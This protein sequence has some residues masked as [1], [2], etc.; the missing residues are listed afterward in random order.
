MLWLEL[1]IGVLVAVVVVLLTAP[2]T[3]R[4]AWSADEQKVIIRYL[5][6]GQTTD[7]AARVRDIDWLGLRLHRSTI[8]AMP[9]VKRKPAPKKPLGP[10]LKTL[11]AHRQTVGRTLKRTLYCTGRLLASPRLRLAR[12]DIVAGSANPALTGMYYG[13]YNSLRPT[14]TSQ[15]IIVNWQPVFHHRQFSARFDGCLWLRLGTPIRQIIRLL[16]ELPKIR[17]YRLYKDLKKKEE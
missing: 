5:G 8:K 14:W 6:F 15:R 1:I 16:Y 17:L 13:W 7:F 12:L 3:I 10:I 11:Y 9:K 2:V 4:V